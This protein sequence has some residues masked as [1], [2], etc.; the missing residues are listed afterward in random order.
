LDNVYLMGVT[1]Y[2]CRECGE[3][4]VRIPNPIS[5]HVILAISMAMKE[6][7]LNGPE[8]RFMRKE[9]GMSAKKF[10]EMICVSPVTLS[11]W[12]TGEMK[13]KPS[14]DQLVRYAFKLMM[15]HRLSTLISYLEDQVQKSEAISRERNRIDV[16]TDHMKYISIPRTEYN[17]TE[18][19]GG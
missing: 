8:I 1:Q 3:I 6:G 12:E 2:E 13:P 9:I 14:S 15:Q 18:H 11:N 7:L 19:M 10:A 16:D 17:M 4:E 5:L